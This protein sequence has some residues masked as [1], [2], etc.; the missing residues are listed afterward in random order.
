M[1]SRLCEF[2]SE[3]DNLLKVKAMEL[4]MNTLRRRQEVTCLTNM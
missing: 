2:I 3:Y 4:L 1:I